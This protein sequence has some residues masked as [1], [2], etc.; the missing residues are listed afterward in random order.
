MDQ[1]RNMTPINSL[2]RPSYITNK[3]R[4]MKYLKASKGKIVKY[5]MQYCSLKFKVAFSFRDASPFADRLTRG[6]ALDSTEGTAP[7]PPL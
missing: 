2:Y 5:G 7:M 1:P 3:P 4:W 6:F